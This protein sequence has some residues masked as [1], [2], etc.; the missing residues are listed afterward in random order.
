MTDPEMSG[1]GVAVA[2]TELRV[3]LPLPRSETGEPESSKNR[4]MK[5]PASV[6]TKTKQRKSAIDRKTFMEN[7][8]KC[9]FTPEKTVY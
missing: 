4:I 1:V 8:P 5:Y 3:L 2:V 9:V 6:A 7:L